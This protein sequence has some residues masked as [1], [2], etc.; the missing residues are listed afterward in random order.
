M[1]STVISSPSSIRSAPSLASSSSSSSSSLQPWPALLRTLP[2]S[3]SLV[4]PALALAIARDPVG[5]ARFVVPAL[6]FVVIPL[7]DALLGNEVRMA[8]P[9]QAATSARSWRYDLWLWAWVPLQLAAV[10]AAIARVPA[11]FAAGE[12]SAPGLASVIVA[13]GLA[14]GIGINVAH[15]LM[16]RR[17]RLERALAEV[18]MT[19]TTYTHFCVEHVLGHH[20][21][22]ATPVDPASS[23]LGESLYVYLPRTLL[24]GVRSAW[25]L[26]GQRR[27]NARIPWWSLKNRQLRYPLVLAAVYVGIAVVTGPVGVLF[28]AGQ[29]LM[30]MLLLETINYIEHYGLARRELSPGRYERCLPWHSWNA[31]QRLT[32]WFLLHLQRHADHH[33]I[34]SRPYYALR[35]VDESPQLPFG[36]ATMV[37]LALVPPLWRRVM[38]ERAVAWNARQRALEEARDVG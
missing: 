10:V 35:H 23:R 17:G 33:H 9:E 5:P 20:K 31:S 13:F 27:K 8:E 36:Y 1:T 19:T 34:A 6:I 15:E 16:H 32:N 25:R 24:G 28:F 7:L 2:F 29:G 3:I 22:V 30:A 26:E 11:A 18:L 12:L 14:T 21:H 4:V 38:D 37:L